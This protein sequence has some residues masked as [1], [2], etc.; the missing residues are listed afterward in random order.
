MTRTIEPAS[1]LLRNGA[2][3]SA[4]DTELQSGMSLRIHNG[5]IQAVT[6]DRLMQPAPHERVID[7][8]GAAVLPGLIDAHVHLAFVPGAPFRGDSVD[9]LRALRREHLKAYIACG[10]TTIMDAGICDQYGTEITEWLND[11]EVG[12]RYRFLVPMLTPRGYISD[13]FTEH[14]VGNAEQIERNF[15]RIMDS[16][17]F[18]VKTTIEYGALPLAHKFPVYT[19]EVRQLIVEGAAKRGLPIFVHALT[20]QAHRESLSLNPYALMHPPHDE[21]SA[22]HMALLAQKGIFI[23]PTLSIVDV[24]NGYKRAGYFDPR[25]LNLVVPE[26]ERTTF[27]DPNLENVFLGHMKKQIMPRWVP[28][29]LLKRL[30]AQRS[31]Q[32]EGMSRALHAFKRAG[33][34]IAMGSD[35]GLSPFLPFAFHGLMSL[36]EIELMVTAAGFTPHEALTAATRHAAQMVQCDHEV[37]TIEAGKIADLVILGSNPL[38]DIRA[39]NDI[40]WVVKNGIIRT[41]EDW[42]Q[43]DCI[44]QIEERARAT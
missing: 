39:I 15:K 14:D 30:V 38:R 26:V 31:R 12:P 8:Q 5:R 37:G 36:K 4:D 19:D 6:P 42:M 28:S 43:A 2:L 27:Q 35:A 25:L 9:Q 21:P 22:D 23:T 16:G 24:F 34:R 1:I 18:G 17:A 29:A 40:R 33:G 3:F 11:G 7:L 32:I 10:I 41:P 44:P 13:I 20:M